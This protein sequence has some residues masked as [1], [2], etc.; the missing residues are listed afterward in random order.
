VLQD[1]VA[2]YGQMNRW[3]EIKPGGEILYVGA[4]NYPSQFLWARIPPVSGTST[5]PLVRTRSLR[6]VSARAS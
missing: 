3:R 2:A 4:D 1:F 6:A 5:L